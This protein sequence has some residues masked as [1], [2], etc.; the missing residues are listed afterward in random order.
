MVQVCGL[1]S[2]GSL[3]GRES[4]SCVHINELSGFIM[5]E[6]FLRQLNQ[7]CYYKGICF[8]Q[9]VCEIVA[10]NEMFQKRLL[11]ASR[12]STF[13]VPS[14]VPLLLKVLLSI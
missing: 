3:W 10:L 11:V 13:K 6:E 2:T 9:L 7:Y 4:G 1:D 12:Y 8:M 14:T 5:V